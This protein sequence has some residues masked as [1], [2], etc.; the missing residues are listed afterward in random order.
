MRYWDKIWFHE[1]ADHSSVAKLRGGNH[2]SSKFLFSRDSCLAVVPLTHAATVAPGYA[3][4]YSVFDIGS[5][6]GLPPRYGGLTFLPSDPNTILV[7]GNANTA[8]GLFYSVP[9]VRGAGD[10]ITGFGTATALGF[11][12]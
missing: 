8:A 9:V 3:S 5:V 4:N 6:G 10:H 2:A 12:G 1:S 11:G 7:G